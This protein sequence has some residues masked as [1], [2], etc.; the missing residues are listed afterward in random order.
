LRNRVWS[1]GC[2]VR[3]VRRPS[4]RRSANFGGEEGTESALTLSVDGD[5]ADQVTNLTVG[6]DESASG[7]LTFD[8]VDQYDPGDTIDWTVALQEFGGSQSGQTQIPTT[9][10]PDLVLGSLE[11]PDSIGLDE[12]LT[13][14]YTVENV[15]DAEGTESAVELLVAGLAA[16]DTDEDVTVGPGESASGTLVFPGVDQFVGEVIEFT[17]ALQDFEDTENGSASVEEASEAEFQ[18]ESI[19]TNAPLVE[20]TDLELTVTVANVGGAAGTQSVTAQAGDLGQASAEFDLDAGSSGQK[21]LVL[22]TEVG[23]TGEHTVTVETDDHSMSESVELHLPPLPNH[24]SPPQNV[25]SDTLYEDVNGDGMVDIFD[26]QTF[27]NNF[28]HT[29]MSGHAWAYDFDGDGDITII[30]VQMLFE[31]E[32]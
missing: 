21:T 26:V 27:F 4:R 32:L 17:V 7:T 23:D 3:R 5:Q 30:D 20:G 9:G 10:E 14:E 1:L 8:G 24:D 28:Q 11:Y 18:V 31:E 19:E 12:D 29:N 25:D 6:P 22:G 13:V 2:R 16:V 15:G